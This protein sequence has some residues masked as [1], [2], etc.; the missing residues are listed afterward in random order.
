MIADL[1]GARFIRFSVLDPYSSGQSSN[2]DVNCPSVEIH[3]Y[4]KYRL[5]DNLG[6]VSDN[7]SIQRDKKYPILY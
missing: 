2:F 6:A 5:K 1:A 3:I 4:V 7:I